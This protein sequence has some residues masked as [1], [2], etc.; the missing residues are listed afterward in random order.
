MIGETIRPLGFQLSEELGYKNFA[1]LQRV[2]NRARDKEPEAK[3]LP[4]IFKTD[5]IPVAVEAFIRNRFKVKESPMPMASD[6]PSVKLNEAMQTI[7]LLESRLEDEQWNAAK[8]QLSLHNSEAKL[9]ELMQ[10]KDN[11]ESL[12]F[13]SSL[14][15]N[16]AKKALAEL[17]KHYI[18]KSDDFENVTDA[19]EN[20]QRE[21]LNLETELS[22]LQDIKGV[23][24]VQAELD[25]A[26]LEQTIETHKAQLLKLAWRLKIPSRLDLINYAEIG[27]SSFGLYVMLGSIGLFVAVIANAFYYDAQKTVK[28]ADA[29]DSASFA[30]FI[31]F[32][33]S[34][35]YSVVHFN[36]FM[37]WIENIEIQYS[38]WWVS[39]AASVL[40]S[41]ISFAALWQSRN[42]TT[43]G[44]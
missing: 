20:A 13:Q 44:Q 35:C 9:D 8:R 40:V 34:L 14:D 18:K 1:D 17:N 5:I 12:Y 24:Q 21:I 25:V 19:L 30:L 15:L 26:N 27:L 41:G 2:Y 10:T 28:N 43:D 33:L 6:D 42:K 4:S 31:T 29:W 37:V 16:D 36:T 11:I 7:Q 39:F 38:K 3:D 32:I 22:L 23:L